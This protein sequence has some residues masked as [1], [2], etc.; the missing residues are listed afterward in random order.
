M[1]LEGLHCWTLWEV[2]EGVLDSWV[3]EGKKTVGLTLQLEPLCVLRG[4]GW[5]VAPGSGEG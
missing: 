4:R 2:M 1:G 5:A 3:R